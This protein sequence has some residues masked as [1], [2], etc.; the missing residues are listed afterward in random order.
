MAN[1]A[2]LY[3]RERPDAWECP[4]RDYRDS[5]WGIPLAWFFCYRPQDIRMVE[6]H[7]QSSHWQEVKLAAERVPALELFQRRQAL[8]LSLVNR[9]VPQS[10][11]AEFQAWVGGRAGSFLLLDPAEV[12]G[13]MSQEETWHAERFAEIFSL[14]DAN[15]DLEAVLEAVCPYVGSFD[16]D[17]DKRLGQV[18]GYT[19]W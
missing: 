8:L 11:I 3:S 17:A 7:F 18:V 14:L 12:L 1:R 19:Y 15:C 13:G 5:R 9:R 2:Y 6:I 4:D 10:V 16:P